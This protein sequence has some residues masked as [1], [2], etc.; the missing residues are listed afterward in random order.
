M[1]VM[2]SDNIAAGKSTS[3]RKSPRTAVGLA[4]PASN[5]K[6]RARKSIDP[7]SRRKAVCGEMSQQQSHSGAQSTPQTLLQLVGYREPEAGRDP[8]SG[9]VKR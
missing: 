5:V 2:G 7:R 3:I 4:A 9:P 6:K 1:A 8:H